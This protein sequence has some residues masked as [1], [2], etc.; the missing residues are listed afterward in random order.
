MS[1]EV[2]FM[3]ETSRTHRTLELW[4]FAAFV[5]L[6][7]PEVALVLIHPTAVWAKETSWKTRMEIRRIKARENLVIK[8]DLSRVG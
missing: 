6:M 1:F 3:F 8:V 2:K 5:I 4:V 7:S